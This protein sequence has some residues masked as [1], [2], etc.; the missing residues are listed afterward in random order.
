MKKVAHFVFL[1]CCVLVARDVFTWVPHMLMVRVEGNPPMEGTLQLL[2][3]DSRYEHVS[4]SVMGTNVSLTL[5]K[6]GSYQLNWVVPGK[7]P[8]EVG[9]FDYK[10]GNHTITVQYHDAALR[11]ADYGNLHPTIRGENEAAMPP[12]GLSVAALRHQEWLNPGLMV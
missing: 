7:D 1:L 10:D 3:K 12:A 9:A 6:T 2:R 4:H 8:Q 11:V 5:S